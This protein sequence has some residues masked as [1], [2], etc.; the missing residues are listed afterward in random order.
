[1]EMMNNSNGRNYSVQPDGSGQGRGKTKARSGK[2]PSRKTCLEEARVAPHSPRSVPTSFDVSSEPELIQGNILR[3]EPFSSGSHR[4]ISVPVQ[5]L[6]QRSHRRGLGNM[7]KPFS[8][9]MNSYLHNKS[10]L[11]QEKT[12][13]L[14]R[15]CSPLYFKEKVKKIKN[16]LKN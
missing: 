8:G 14:L 5:K 4:N 7:P 16:W 3:A 10:F 2:Y 12:I 11:G 15:G 9:A 6:I 13:E 1:M